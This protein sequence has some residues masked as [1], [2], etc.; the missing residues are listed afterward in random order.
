M[1]KNE[2]YEK[3]DKIL[4]EILQ[5]NNYVLDD[6]LMAKDVEGWDSLSHMIIIVQ[7]EETFNTRFKLKELNKMQNMGDLVQIILNK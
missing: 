3:I 5:H 2:V 1:E 4:K 7:I 6:S